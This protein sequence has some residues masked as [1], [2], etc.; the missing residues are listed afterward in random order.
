MDRRRRTQSVVTIARQSRWD[1][2]VGNVRP[3][4][5]YQNAGRQV[6]KRRNL[7]SKLA[8]Y[9]KIINVLNSVTVLTTCLCDIKL[10]GK[11]NGI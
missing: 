6:S 4:T 7:I 8:R 5:S 9:P 11:E 3:Y 1:D 2:I 10:V